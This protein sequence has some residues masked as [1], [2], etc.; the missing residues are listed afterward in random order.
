MMKIVLYAKTDKGGMR[1]HVN[2]L[3]KELSR[4]YEVDVLSQ[5]D[6]P[7]IRIYG[8]FYY[9]DLPKSIGIVKNKLNSCDLFHIHHTATS[10][11]LII[12]FMKSKTP[13]INTFHIAVGSMNQ[14][15]NPLVKM[16][17]WANIRYIKLLSRLYSK[18]TSRIICVGQAIKKIA[19]K[20][21]TKTT[22]I[23]NGVDTRTFKPK[24]SRRYFDDFTV[25]YLGRTD[26]EKNVRA[27][28]K[29]CKMLDVNLVIAGTSLDYCMLKKLEGNNVKF[30]G[31]VKYPPV[32]FYNAID[33]FVSPSVMEGNPYAVLEAM[34]CGKPFIACNI[35]GEGK[36]NPSFGFISKPFP[37]DLKTA[38][39]S[40]MNRDLKKMGKAARQ[41]AV[42]N[43][44]LKVMMKKLLKVYDEVLK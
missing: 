4:K 30:V 15:R 43:Y 14:I 26:P 24:R 12:P 33:L 6:L 20:Y 34:A 5:D 23:N 39:Y 16:F 38:I 18:R 1:T 28:V 36:V 13:I 11:E 31:H 8:G 29:A 44:D 41:E 9:V 21:T 10:S 40:M 22:V 42:K 32:Q 37:K 35:G 27:L 3:E 17:N 25:G 19:R 2:Y 7:T